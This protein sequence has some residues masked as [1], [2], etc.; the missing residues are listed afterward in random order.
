M[1]WSVVSRVV[2]WEARRAIFN[3][4]SLVHIFVDSLILEGRG[5][6]KAAKPDASAIA[7]ACKA[8][9]GAAS[10]KATFIGVVRQRARR[11]IS[12]PYIVV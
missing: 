9:S 2:M 1:S 12:V 6:A 11:V 10:G 8:E 5:R 7:V 3:N 4:E